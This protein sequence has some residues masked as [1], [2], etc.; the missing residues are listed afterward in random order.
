MTLDNLYQQY[1]DGWHLDIIEKFSGNKVNTPNIMSN[2][3]DKPVKI[4][5]LIVGIKNIGIGIIN[6]D[7]TVSR[8]LKN[9][10]ND[11]VETFVNRMYSRYNILRNTHL[12]KEVIEYPININYIINKRPYNNIE[13]LFDKLN[14]HYTNKFN[15]NIIDYSKYNFEEQLNILN[16][17]GII[18]CGVG[19]ARTRTPLLPNG[20]IEIQ[21]NT[22]CLSLP[23]N[24]NYYDYHI[25]TL[26]KYIKIYNITQYTIEECINEKYSQELENIIDECIN[27]FTHIK[28][29]INIDNNIPQY[30]LNL[31][32][33]IDEYAFA[34]WR[35]S[36]SNDIGDLIKSIYML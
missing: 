15:F 2:M 24:I 12:N 18:I 27:I 11:P 7:F 21:T 5:Y 3:F 17:T 34:R 14:K 33:K 4:P 28:F 1:S 35:N 9:H 8:Q 30:I 10:I 32:G 20:S 6:S 26:S 29:P 25:G 23:N 31:K 22:H 13:S 19:T 16:N 36:L